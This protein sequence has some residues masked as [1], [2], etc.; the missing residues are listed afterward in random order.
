MMYATVLV[1]SPTLVAIGSFL[2][3]E[4]ETATSLS[5]IEAKIESLGEHIA[6]PKGLIILRPITSLEMHSA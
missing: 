6:V 4:R 3:G 2:C 1:M 5:V